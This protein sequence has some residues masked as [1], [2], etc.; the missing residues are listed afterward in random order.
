MSSIIELRKQ[1]LASQVNQMISDVQF[2]IDN[3]RRNENATSISQYLEFNEGQLDRIKNNLQK[4]KN[5]FNPQ[6]DNFGAFENC[7]RQLKELQNDINQIQSRGESKLS[8]LQF[9]LPIKILISIILSWIYIWIWLVYW[10]WVDG[11]AYITMIAMWV[12]LPLY[13]FLLLF[14][15]IEEDNG[16]PSFKWF[17]RFFTE[18]L[19]ED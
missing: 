6:S 2:F 10:H 14:Y 17:R 3:K 15:Y 19:L 12:Y 7:I 4:I 16:Y 9:L 8:N 1:E 13:P 5:S 18:L 11:W